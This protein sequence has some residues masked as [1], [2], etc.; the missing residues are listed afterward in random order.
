MSSEHGLSTEELL[1][2]LLAREVRDHEISACGALSFIPATAMLLGRELHAPNA[3]IIILNS[4]EYDPF[5]TSKEFHFLAQRGRL[6]LF[7]ISAI[8]IDRRGNFNLHVIG[9][10]DAPDVLLPGQY[11]TGMLYY[12]VPRIVMFRTEHTRRTF[13]EHVDYV[14]G[15]GTSP[16]GVR[17]RNRDIKVITPIA[18]LRL[19]QGTRL[20]ELESVHQGVTVHHVV[21]NTA[22]DLG[23]DGPVES[24]PAITEAEVTALRSVVKAHMIETDTY[25]DEAARLI[26]S[27]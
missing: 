25:A 4:S 9:D 20:M 7:F 15:A 5:V 23:V 12:A 18:A 3:E 19:N 10:R 24:T 8:E 14:S 11:G 17:R 22:F 26:K 13:V 6:D 27:A 21:E 2:I 1:A 16:E